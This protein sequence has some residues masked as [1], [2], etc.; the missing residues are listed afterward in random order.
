MGS[1]EKASWLVIARA[2]FLWGNDLRLMKIRGL[3]PLLVV[4]LRGRGP[5]TSAQLCAA[6][7]IKVRSTW[8]A[9]STLLP[10]SPQLCHLGRNGTSCGFDWSPDRSPHAH[11][12]PT[13]CGES[14]PVR[15][16]VG[17]E[18][19]IHR[20]RDKGIYMRKLKLPQDFTAP[21]RMQI[22]PFSSQPPPPSGGPLGS[23]RI[24]CTG[25]A[26]HDTNHH[27]TP[28]G[29]TATSSSSSSL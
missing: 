29:S 11:P 20:A 24:T 14:L 13:A 7:Q 19:K 5:A 9:I 21:W 15:G 2:L 25:G 18:D 16:L 6:L 17:K 12:T 1:R 8:G 10:P 4:M 28:L 23:A 22:Y 27:G 3:F 26:N